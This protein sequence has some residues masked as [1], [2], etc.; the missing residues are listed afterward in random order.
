MS[1]VTPAV[2]YAGHIEIGSGYLGQD[3]ERGLH[4]LPDSLNVSVV[5]VLMLGMRIM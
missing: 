5:Y 1:S 4:D 2:D 3:L